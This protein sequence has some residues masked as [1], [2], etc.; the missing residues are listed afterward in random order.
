MT[1]ASATPAASTVV[2]ADGSGK[3]DAAW[4]P[5]AGLVA[6]TAVGGDL[7]GTLPNPTVTA[8][9]FAAPGPIGSVTPSTIAATQITLGAASNV[10]LDTATGTKLGTDVLQKLALW[11]AT[12]IVQ[13]ASAAQAAVATTA[14]TNVAP[15]G[16]ATQAQ[17]DAIIT[18]LNEIRSALVAIGAIKGSA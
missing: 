15:Y 9:R 2:K 14:A 8:A 11:N 16:F 13:P 3:I 12:P 7:A 17:A 18:L 4:L 6:G 1:A 10:I 5:A